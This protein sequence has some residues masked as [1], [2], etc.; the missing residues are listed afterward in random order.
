M[1]QH[2]GNGK[3]LSKASERNA[4]DAWFQKDKGR[5]GWVRQME[6]ER[7]REKDGI[8]VDRPLQPTRIGLP[9]S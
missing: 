6:R 9:G 7:R 4:A 1:L 8:W 2:G 5:G 3:S